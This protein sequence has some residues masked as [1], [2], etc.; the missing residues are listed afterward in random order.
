[1]TDDI[2]EGLANPSSVS[3]RM[4]NEDSIVVFHKRI[5]SFEALKGV[6]IC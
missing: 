3:G 5:L 2:F 4:V 6:G 1:M